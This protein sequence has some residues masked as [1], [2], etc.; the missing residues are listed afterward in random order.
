[1]RT[2]W[3]IGIVKRYYILL[4]RVYK[5]IANDLQGC[6]LS[7]KIILQIAVK[8]INN[9][10]SFNGLVPTL[11]IF[12]AYSCILKFYFPTSIISQRAT[13]IKNTMKKVQKVKAERQLAN[14][15]N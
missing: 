5:V 9:I 4:Q 14:A 7:K 6:G 8:A 1:M 11:L 15:L 3:L 12:G 13:A 2:T 10:S